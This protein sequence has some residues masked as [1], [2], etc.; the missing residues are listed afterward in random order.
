MLQSRMSVIAT[1]P[2]SPNPDNLRLEAVTICVGFDDILD[3]T[4]PLN[5]PHLDTMIVVTSFDDYKT[6]QVA[7]KHGAICVQSDLFTKNDRKFNKGAAINDGFNYFQYNGWRLHL[8]ADIILPDNFR[9]I[10]F[11][12]THL[13]PDCIY[14]ADRQNVVGWREL[15]TARENPQH[16]QRLLLHG[17]GTRAHGHRLID[18][19]HGYLPIGYFQMWH[20]KAQKPYPYSMGTAAHDDMMFSALWPRTQ[21]RLLPSVIVHHLVPKEHAPIGENWEGRKHPRIT[22]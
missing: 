13:D 9:R 12:H 4:L 22:K 6:K 10:I 5:H 11:N 3:H 1:R 7:N 17:G 20:A 14:G 21:R 16:A 8:D 15:T 2:P 18:L 19:L